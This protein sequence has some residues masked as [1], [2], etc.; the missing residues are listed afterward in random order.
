MLVE[1]RNRKNKK[2][3]KIL[4]SLYSSLNKGIT[5][6]GDKFQRKGL[7]GHLPDFKNPPPGCRFSPRC[8]FSEAQCREKRLLYV[9]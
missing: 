5:R 4:A 9:R 3:L 1:S 6:L 7:S 8:P 2:S